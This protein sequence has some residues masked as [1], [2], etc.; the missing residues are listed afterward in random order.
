MAQ[1]PQVL[2]VVTKAVYDVNRQR[3][4]SLRTM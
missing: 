3:L 1:G 4:N 2:H